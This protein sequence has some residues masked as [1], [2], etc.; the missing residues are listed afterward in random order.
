MEVDADLLE[1][2]A[3]SYCSARSYLDIDELSQQIIM[4]VAENN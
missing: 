4:G 3:F 2:V 1:V